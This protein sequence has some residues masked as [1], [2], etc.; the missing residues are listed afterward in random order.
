MIAMRRPRDEHKLKRKIR[1]LFLTN[2]LMIYK[3][4]DGHI[5]TRDATRI[6]MCCIYDINDAFYFDYQIR[7]HHLDCYLSKYMNHTE[8]FTALQYLK[9]LGYVENL[10]GQK[11]DFSFNLT[12]A[13]MNYFELRNKNFVYLVFNSVFLPVIIS[14]VTT[15]ATLL[16]SGVL[17]PSP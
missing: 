3:T 1:F 9:D 12:Y 13:G 2:P 16:I 7:C 4:I 5:L 10:H 6:L 15:L 11:D 14:I 8:L 17:Q